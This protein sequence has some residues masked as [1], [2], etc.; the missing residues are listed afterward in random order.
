MDTTFGYARASDGA[1][2]GYRIDG[3]GPIDIVQ[4]P[5]WPGNIDLEWDDP[6]PARGSG[7]WPRWADSSCTTTEGWIS[8]RDWGPPRSRPAS[9]I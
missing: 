4:Q 8:S 3:D 2:I 7:G 5:E 6:G 9:P 1:Y